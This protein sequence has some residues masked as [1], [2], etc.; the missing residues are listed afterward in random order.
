MLTRSMP[1]LAAEKFLLVRPTQVQPR[2]AFPSMAKRFPPLAERTMTVK[3]RRV[4][5][6]FPHISLLDFVRAVR[7][8]NQAQLEKWVQKAR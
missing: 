5:E 3:F 7:A 4:T 2:Q 6:T 1:L 8:G